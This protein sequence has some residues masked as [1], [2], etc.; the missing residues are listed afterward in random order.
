M[1]PLPALTSGMFLTIG[2]S[3]VLKVSKFGWQIAIAFA[4]PA[5]AVA[6]SPAAANPAAAVSCSLVYCFFTSYLAVSA[7]Y[8]LYAA[9][10]A[11]PFPG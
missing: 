3:T 6:A 8:I 7:L 11:S 9:G 4:Y 10:A 5:K 2:V 1:R